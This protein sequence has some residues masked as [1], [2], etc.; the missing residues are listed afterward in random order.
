MCLLAHHPGPMCNNTN[1]HFG[2]YSKNRHLLTPTNVPFNGIVPGKAAMP[3]R[4]IMLYRR[5]NV[6]IVLGT[7]TSRKGLLN[8]AGDPPG[9]NAGMIDPASS[10]RDVPVNLTLQLTRRESLSGI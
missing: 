4:Q 3:L 7:P 1:L 8:G 6:S 5:E 2:V 9:F 10:S